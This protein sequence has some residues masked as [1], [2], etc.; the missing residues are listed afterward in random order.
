M[1]TFSGNKQAILCGSEASS[2]P[3][4]GGDSGKIGYTEIHT[5]ICN[6]YFQCSG[7]MQIFFMDLKKE[8][9]ITI[10]AEQ[11][12]CVQKNHEKEY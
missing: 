10:L 7:K 9:F 4:S 8:R 3:V 12:D 6:L 2:R 11:W 1:N 5:K